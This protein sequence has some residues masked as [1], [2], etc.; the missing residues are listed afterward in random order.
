MSEIIGD[1]NPNYCGEYHREY[2][3]KFK[4]IQGIIEH[5][6]MTVLH[7]QETVIH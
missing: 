1:T 6:K 3:K 5:L 2:L 7:R 4:T